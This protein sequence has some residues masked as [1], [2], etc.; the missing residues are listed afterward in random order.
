MPS[1]DEIMLVD[2]HPAN[3]R[4]LEEAFTEI[5]VPVALRRAG[6]VDEAIALLRAERKPPLAVLCDVDMPG[7]D[8]RHL[9]HYVKSTPA[10][11]GV[12]MVMLAPTDLPVVRFEC[13]DL[14]ADAVVDKPSDWDGYLD[15]VRAVRRRFVRTAAAGTGRHRRTVGT[16]ASH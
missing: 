9:L 5:R 10:L 13:Q 3:L 1:R 14:A 12:A 16:V 4:L 8:G 6:T 7:R 11:A 15:L 2:D